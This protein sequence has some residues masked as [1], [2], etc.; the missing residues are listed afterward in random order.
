M[1]AEVEFS[2]RLPQTAMAVRVRSAVQDLGAAFG[3]G[4]AAIGVY[5]D[6]EGVTPTGAPFGI[7]HNMDM[8]DLDVEMGI[9]VPEPLAGDGNVYAM[10]IPGG[11]WATK[12]HVGP[13][14]QV[15]PVYEDLMAA[16]TEK[17]YAPAGMSCEFYL[18][19]PETVP[20]DQVQTLVGFPLQTA[21][22]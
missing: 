13:Y 3:T 10:E 20:P 11:M 5:L 2:E 15:G 7:Y 19:D 8:E 16:L 12:L 18:N 14:D 17:G 9:P 1:S 4:Y 6:Q 21:S 22:G